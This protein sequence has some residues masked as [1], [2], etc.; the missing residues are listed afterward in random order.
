MTGYTVHTGSTVKFSDGWDN[1]FGGASG[2][3]TTRV[4]KRPKKTAAQKPTVA[5]KGAKAHRARRAR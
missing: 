3:A 5:K 2:K 1:I 4:A